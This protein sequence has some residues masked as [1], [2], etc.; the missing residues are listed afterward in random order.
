MGTLAPVECKVLKNKLSFGILVVGA[1][2]LFPCRL[3][4]ASSL[5]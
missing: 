5:Q 1:A 2:D 4:S 3:Y